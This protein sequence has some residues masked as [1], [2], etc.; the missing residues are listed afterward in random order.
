[1]FFGIIAV[2]L[3]IAFYGSRKD[4]AKRRID[5]LQIK[6]GQEA[7]EK[8]YIDVYLKLNE[9]VNRLEEY[10]KDFKP[11]IGMKSMKQINDEIS[12]EIEEIINSE[13][14]KEVY[15]VEERKQELKPVLDEL[16]KSKPSKWE[17]EA[18]FAINLIKAKAKSL[19]IVNSNLDTNIDKK[20]EQKD[21]IVN[22]SDLT[23]K[24]IK[25][26]LNEKGIEFKSSSKKSELVELLEKEEK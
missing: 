11:S 8:K 23:V 7:S 4:K 6:E 21:E 5:Q 2:L 13:D 19:E 25:D 24:E 22:Y 18:F 16:K 26:L 10:L 14:L 3:I 20:E 15:F 17:L 12:F 1:M 9:I